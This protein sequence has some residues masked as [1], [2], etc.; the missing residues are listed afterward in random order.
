MGSELYKTLYFL[1]FG[2]LVRDRCAGC[3]VSAQGPHSQP[4]QNRLQVCVQSVGT[5]TLPDCEEPRPTLATHLTSLLLI[6]SRVVVALQNTLPLSRTNLLRAWSLINPSPAGFDPDSLVFKV[7]VT[8]KG[9][10]T[11]HTADDQDM[12]CG[13]LRVHPCWRPQGNQAPC[14][15]RRGQEGYF[16]MGPSSCLPRHLWTPTCLSTNAAEECYCVLLHTVIPR[17]V[18]VCA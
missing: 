6:K 5:V 12:A 1:G 16:S 8:C 15:T 18:R 2:P 4:Q 10:D 11:R 13:M 7:L 14:S 17:P 9:Q 3:S